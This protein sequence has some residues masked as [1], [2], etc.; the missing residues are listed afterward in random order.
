MYH[1]GTCFRPLP[2]QPH[3][4]F[5]STTKALRLNTTLKSLNLA[6]ECE[7]GGGRREEEEGGGSEGVLLRV[8]ASSSL[9]ILILE[10]SIF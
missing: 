3:L 6:S 2:A 5:I 9:M 4:P 10:V 7:E 1:V 8:C